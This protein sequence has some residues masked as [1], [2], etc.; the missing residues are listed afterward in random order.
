MRN[1]LDCVNINVRR[2]YIVHL[3]VKPALHEHCSPSVA[4]SFWGIRVIASRAMHICKYGRI[5]KCGNTI[6][7]CRLAQI[8]ELFDSCHF[9]NIR[10][11]VA[12]NLTGEQMNHHYTLLVIWRTFSHYSAKS[13]APA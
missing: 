4:N 13:A 8:F 7:A 9:T 12:S 5:I 11:E 1:G 10:W 2:L 6:H 3:C